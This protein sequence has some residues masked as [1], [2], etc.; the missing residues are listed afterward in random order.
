[1]DGPHRRVAA[2]AGSSQPCKWFLLLVFSLFQMV[3]RRRST[4]FRRRRFGGFR[5]RSRYG[6]FSRYTG[7]RSRPTVMHRRPMR[8]E[9]KKLDT[10][11]VDASIDSAGVISALFDP[12][13][14]TDQMSMLG[15][16]CQIRYIYWRCTL[17]T[18]GTLTIAPIIRVMLFVDKK[19]TSAS[20]PTVA[21]DNDTA[22]LQN[23]TV[24]SPLSNFSVGRYTILSDRTF[25]LK[26]GANVADAAGTGNVVNQPTFYSVFRRL[27]FTWT[28]DSSTTEPSQ[29]RIFCLF[30]TDQDE[31]GAIDAICRIGFTDS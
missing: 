9:V 8:P 7:R 23:P 4:R 27:N 28:T 6:R 10:A 20:A 11:V 30:I 14:G 3:F 31:I 16:R 17:R 24:N 15:M 12:S 26:T 29:N 13:I 2:F 18:S 21:G 25:A 19:G 5:G 22:V 1:M